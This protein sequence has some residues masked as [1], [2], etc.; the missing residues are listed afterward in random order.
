LAQSGA[1]GV[2]VGRAS[3]GRPWAISNMLEF[4][5]SGERRPEPGAAERGVLMMHHLDSI[6]E[7]YGPQCGLGLAKKHAAWYSKCLSNSAEFRASLGVV[8]S[9]EKLFGLLGE[10]FSCER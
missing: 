5:R 7:F 2:M 9:I 4:L 6:V 8:D 10:F 3:Y 1:D